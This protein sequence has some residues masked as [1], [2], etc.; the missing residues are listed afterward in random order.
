MEV[1]AGGG[2]AATAMS[3]GS[4][5]QPRKSRVGATLGVLPPWHSHAN[6]EM[7]AQRA[8]ARHLAP[9]HPEAGGP[10][11]HTALPSA[12]PRP[13]SAHLLPSPQSLCVAGPGLLWNAGSVDL[14]L[15][16]AQFRSSH[17]TFTRRGAAQTFHGS[18]WLFTCRWNVQTAGL[19][20]SK[21]RVSRA[22]GQS[23]W[24]SA[25]SRQQS[26]PCPADT[27][28]PARVTKYEIHIHFLFS[29]DINFKSRP[30]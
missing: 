3:P 11:A 17:S 15:R 30:R 9:P 2:D 29:Q 26:P 12:P 4:Q 28:G 22:A 18:I 5:G 14:L 1:M 21:E 13:A 16:P 27:A 19:F 25:A 10:Q 7:G 20:S 8:S 24:V 6:P 23:R